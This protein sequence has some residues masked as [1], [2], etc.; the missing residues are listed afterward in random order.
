MMKKGKALILL[1]VAATLVSACTSKN[2]GTSTATGTSATAAPNEKVDQ[3]KMPNPI[4]ITTFKGVTANAKLPEGDS[5][6]NNPYTRY[7]KDKTNI[8]FKLLW[9]ASGADYT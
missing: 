9:Y 7:I 5:A 4:E 6:E 3:F 1:A 8:S 2:P